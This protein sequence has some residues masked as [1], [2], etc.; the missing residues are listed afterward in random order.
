VSW[1][2]SKGAAAKEPPGAKCGRALTLTGVLDIDAEA[3]TQA[4]SAPDRRAV[5]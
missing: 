5:S 4:P 2:A 1:I 3:T